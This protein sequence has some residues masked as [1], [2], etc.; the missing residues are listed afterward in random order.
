M[1]ACSR[2]ISS[3]ERREV[4]V[5]GREPGAVQDLVG[6]RVPDPGEEPGVGERAL[7]RVALAR[8]RRAE[9]G[10]IGVERLEPAA[11]ERGER[12]G[13]ADEVERRAPL[14]ARLGEHERALREVERGE[15]DAA[16][17][18]R[19]RLAPVEPARDHEVD[20]EEEVALEREDD[21]LAHAAHALDVL[22]RGRRERRVDG[23][24]HERAS[25]PDAQQR[26]AP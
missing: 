16:G 15:P 7:E 25:Q 8:Q 19:V 23:A 11:I 17:E 26:R 20:H 22:P 13:A 10:E 21:A 1:A 6:V 4:S 2:A 3:S 12:G 9:G 24:E 18:L 14:R 5:T